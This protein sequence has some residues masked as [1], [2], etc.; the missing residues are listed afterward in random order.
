MAKEYT[1]RFVVKAVHHGREHIVSIP[2][3]ADRYEGREGVKRLE[4]LALGSTN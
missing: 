3:Y 1:D 2:K 4:R